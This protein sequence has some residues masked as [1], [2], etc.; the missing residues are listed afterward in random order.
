[1]PVAVDDDE[2]TLKVISVQKPPD[3]IHEM[4]SAHQGDMDRI[5]GRLRSLGTE[6]SEIEE[7]VRTLESR[8]AT[9]EERLLEQ[10][11]MLLDLRNLIGKVQIDV[12]RLQTD[13]SGVIEA[14]TG[15][16]TTLREHMHAETQQALNHTKSIH[17]LSRVLIG[18]FAALAVLSVTIMGAVSL[19]TGEGLALGD[20]IKL[21]GL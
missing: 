12:H 4:F 21:L 18:V 2:D 9:T 10:R 5:Y 14:Q 19:L 7:R 15:F 1:V 6:T 20:L 3:S 11:S 17:T 8:V 13:I 16:N